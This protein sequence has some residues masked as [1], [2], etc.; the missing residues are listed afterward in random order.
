MAS[1][2]EIY[3]DSEQGYDSEHEVDLDRE[4][5]SD[6]GGEALISHLFGPPLYAPPYK[7]IVKDASSDPEG[8]ERS[9]PY[10]VREVSPELDARELVGIRAREIS[11]EIIIRE[12]GG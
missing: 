4:F 9:S 12:V 8:Q 1:N 2:S 10:L 6:A 7:R 11:P 3:W 5:S